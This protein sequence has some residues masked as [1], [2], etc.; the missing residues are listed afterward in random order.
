MG[1]L[2]NFILILS[3]LSCSSAGEKIGVGVMKHRLTMKTGHGAG[4]VAVEPKS[5]YVF[6]FEWKD[7]AELIKITTCHREI[8]VEANRI[9]R[10]KKEYK[11][12]Y[13]PT[14][15]EKSGIC[16]IFIGAYDTKG[17]HAWAY[18][19]TRLPS[20]NLKAS[21]DCSGSQRASIGLSVCQA[22]TGLA[23]RISFTSK[24]IYTPSEGCS[25]L[26][27]LKGNA[28]EFSVESGLCHYVFSDIKT[29]Q[30]HRLTAYGYDEVLLRE[31]KAEVQ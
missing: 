17:Q 30:I 26:T 24:V 10:S 15:I 4:M 2:S 22:R 9:F 12:K 5:N 14:E 3:V 6:N 31:F 23:Q 21:I 27:K 7:R 25:N 1:W 28:Y 8:V 29:K 11:W 19:D 18:I 16:P 20:E 13:K